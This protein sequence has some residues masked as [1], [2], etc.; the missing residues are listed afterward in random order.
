MSLII[1][2]RV[3]VSFVFECFYFPIWWYTRGALLM[4]Q[5][6]R[7]LARAGS[8]L[9]SPAVWW[10]YLFVPMYG[11][12]NWQGRIISFLVRLVQGIVRGLFFLA[13]FAMIV[14]ITGL[15]FVV[16]FI[17]VQIIGRALVQ[18]L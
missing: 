8:E 5:A 9:L 2:Q 11:Q 6:G 18:A 17:L 1:V 15:W 12:Y 7:R 10:R 4:F 3:L 13:W 16:P 14:L